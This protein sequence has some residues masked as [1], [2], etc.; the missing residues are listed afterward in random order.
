MM[1]QHDGDGQSLLIE[2]V[3]LDIIPLQCHHTCQE[4]ERARNT[5]PMPHLLV[6]PQALGKV[7][8]GTSHVTLVKGYL[9]Q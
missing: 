4:E 5:L 2:G 3:S 7:I 9:S 8:A 1:L 6:E